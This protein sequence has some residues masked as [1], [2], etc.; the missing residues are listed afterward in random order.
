[1]P[2]TALATDPR[3]TVQPATPVAQNSDPTDS[4]F[5]RVSWLYAF[6]REHLFRDDTGRIISTLWPN[7]NPLAGTKVIELGCGPG[8]YS[9]KLAQRFPQLVVLGVDRSESQLRS[10]RQRA[11]AERVANCFFQ[12]VN[13]LSL[14]FEDASFDVL[15]ASRILTV[16]PDHKRAVAEMFRVLKPGGRCFIAEPCH[17]FWASIPLTSMWLLASLIHSG[18]GY[19]EPKKATVLK[20]DAFASLFGDQPWKS[21]RIWKDGRYQYALC[22]K[23]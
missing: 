12:R 19:R 20:R 10:A 18:N 23:G 15:I 4:L 2:P 13:A 8:F 5:E 6:C 3:P 21:V 14:R 9:R 7:E 16:L 1:M 22:E 11:S 17:A